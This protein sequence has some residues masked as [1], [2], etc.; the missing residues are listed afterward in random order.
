MEVIIQI[1]CIC[2]FI[3]F[4]VVIT[5]MSVA[6]LLA[7]PEVP[8]LGREIGHNGLLKR[9]FAFAI[10]MPNQVLRY[11]VRRFHSTHLPSVH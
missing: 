4:V 3:Q 8:M 1:T 2:F 5:I 7:R 11:A 10:Q 6:L 9:G